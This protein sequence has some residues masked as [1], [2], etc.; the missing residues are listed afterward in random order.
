MII[1]YVRPGWIPPAGSLAITSAFSDIHQ[2]IP[3]IALD[4]GE[5]GPL[6]WLKKKKSI[7]AF[8]DAGAACSDTTLFGWPRDHVLSV[9]LRGISED[10]KRFY[11]EDI[12]ALVVRKT[13]MGKINNIVLAVLAAFM[14]WMAY[15]WRSEVPEFFLVLAGI[16]VAALLYNF[17]SRSHGPGLYTHRGSVRKAADPGPVTDRAK[18]RIQNKIPDRD[19]ARPGESG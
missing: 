14:A 3:S 13:A 1:F 5:R 9:T 12:Q 18:G 11:F 10:Y 8:P 19:V 6:Q 2:T 16:L 15:I 7:S 4:R 17:F